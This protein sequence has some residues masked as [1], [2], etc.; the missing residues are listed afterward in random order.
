MLA[1]FIDVVGAGTPEQPSSGYAIQIDRS[2]LWCIGVVFP[3]KKEV[4]IAE[5]NAARDVQNMTK[6]KVICG[7]PGTGDYAK[8]CKVV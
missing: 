7:A 8:S 1:G 6:A 3:S 2:M 4:A 5:A